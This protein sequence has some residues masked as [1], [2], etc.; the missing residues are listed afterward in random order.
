[1]LQTV[2]SVKAV[3][4]QIVPVVHS[5]EMCHVTNQPFFSNPSSP[6]FPVWPDCTNGWQC[7]C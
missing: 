1:V 4:H 5:A 2:V 6:S 3:R 7:R